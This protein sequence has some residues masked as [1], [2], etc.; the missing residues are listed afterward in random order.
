MDR[1]FCA[2]LTHGKHRLVCKI[3]DSRDIQTEPKREA[4]A[5]L[6]RGSDVGCAGLREWLGKATRMTTLTHRTSPLPASTLL[7]IAVA[8]G[9]IG[10]ERFGYY[11]L[12]SVVI[13]RATNLNEMAN[14][15]RWLQPIGFAF[16]VGA[17]LCTLVIPPRWMA[18]IGATSVVAGHLAMGSASPLVVVSLAYAGGAVMRLGLFSTM[19]RLV[20]KDESDCARVFIIATLVF[21]FVDVGAFIAPLVFGFARVRGLVLFASA[22]TGVMIALTTVGAA[23]LSRHGPTQRVAVVA[24]PEDVAM[25]DPREKRHPYRAYRAVGPSSG[26]SSPKALVLL[27]ATALAVGLLLFEAAMFAPNPIFLSKHASTGAPWMWVVA[28][29]RILTT[30]GSAVLV[31]LLPSFSKT[32]VLRILAF[33]AQ[34]AGLCGSLAGLAALVAHTGR[35]PLEE[36]V[37]FHTVA[38]LG[39]PMLFAA[40]YAIAGLVLPRKFAPIAI[41]SLAAMSTLMSAI[42]P[43]MHGV[44]P[45]LTLLAGLLTS[46]V[47]VALLIMARPISRFWE[48]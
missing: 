15:L 22:T 29:F 1:A 21:V 37:V 7:A 11:G 4:A 39:E 25:F 47:A 32:V 16:L 2:G 35:E 46:A 27:G 9:A 33:G 23:F 24:P 43:A 20:P 30:L 41:G 6:T 10:L 44:A 13:A 8:C 34:C 14:A 42:A 17:T 38:S 45:V 48:V 28:C 3:D 19:I 5:T 26:V 12:R 40:A 31:S 18:V 36:F